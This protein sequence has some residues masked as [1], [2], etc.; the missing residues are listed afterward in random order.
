MPIWQLSR[1]TNFSTA[2]VI[3]FDARFRLSASSRAFTKRHWMTEYYVAAALIV[4]LALAVMFI[5]S[6]VQQ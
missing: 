4:V 1:G 2:F 3:Q 6:K 5:I